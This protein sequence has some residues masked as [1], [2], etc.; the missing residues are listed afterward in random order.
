[1]KN[2]RERILSRY[3]HLNKQEKKVAEMVLNH[4]EKVIYQSIKEAAQSCDVSETT[5]FRFCHQMGFEGFLDFK[6]DL[7]RSLRQF[8]FDSDV[9][10]N[11]RDDVFG[12][13]YLLHEKIN[14]V[15]DHVIQDNAAGTLEQM[16]EDIVQKDHVLIFAL[17]DE[18]SVAEYFARRLCVWKKVSVQTDSELMKVQYLLNDPKTFLLIIDLADRD[19]FADLLSQGERLGKTAA[20]VADEQQRLVLR[21]GTHLVAGTD[22]HNRYGLYGAF[23][24]VDIILSLL[25]KK[26]SQD[27]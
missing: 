26:L 21:C 3:V 25:T 8:E 5:V 20:V 16:V 2:V 18:K 12:V 13:S 15:L 27:Q 11:Q 23:Y 22:I 7:A 10:L 6:I 1:M 17:G 24:V 4:S 19:F 9:D 14:R